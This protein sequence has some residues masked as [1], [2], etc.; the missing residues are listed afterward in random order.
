MTYFPI[1]VDINNR[2]CTVIGGGQ[3]AERKVKGLLACHGRVMVISPEVTTELADL[4]S[5]SVIKW[6]ARGYEKGDLAESFMVIAATDDEEVQEKVHE[7]ALE[8]NI[9]LN[10]AD[11]PK[12]C[13]FILPATIR[14]GDLTISISTSGK[15]PA[16]ARRTRQRL[17]EEFGPEYDLALQL[18][19]ALRPIVLDLG[20]PHKEN[21][22]IFEKI[23]HPDLL[24]WLQD[25]SW[26]LVEDHIVEILGDEAVVKNLLA[27]V[28]K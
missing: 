5:R 9:L 4:A 12:W 7:E 15:S 14:R 26:Q 8:A 11:V 21:K 6:Q 10:V 1:N 28:K 24:D 19:G 18:M 23:L 2:H 17:E 22:I 16:L 25:G 27:E 20:K 13:N 3:V